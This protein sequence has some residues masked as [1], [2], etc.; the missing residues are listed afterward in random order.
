MP[1]SLRDQLIRDEGV[2]LKPYRDSVG[3]LTIGCGRNLDDVGISMT[4]LD[5]LL[6]NDVSRTVAAVLAH[7]PWAVTLD[8]IRRDVLVN[9]AFNL[10][11]AGLMGFKKFLAAVQ[12]GA[13]DDAVI[14]MLDSKWHEQV[15][16]RAERLAEQ[17]L[18][19]DSYR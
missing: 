12:R 4:E 10:G 7:L 8:P 14:E 16:I 17:M 5:I 11:I 2:R 1:D 6:D 15:G 18:H 9:M 3:K 13:W 19:G